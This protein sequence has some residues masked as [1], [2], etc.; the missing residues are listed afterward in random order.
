VRIGLLT[1]DT[2]LA[3]KVIHRL[4]LELGEQV[5][6]VLE[7]TVILPGKSD[8]ASTWFLLSRSS[9]R[10][11]T[12]RK[13]TELLVGRTIELSAK[14]THRR[15]NT[16][17]LA[18]LASQFSVPLVRTADINEPHVQ[19]ALAQWDPD[20][21]VSV[22]M[23]QR[24]GP[25]LIALPPRGVINVH[26]ALLPRNRG[27]FPYFWALAN[28]DQ[29]TGST[30]HWVDTGLDTGPILLQRELAIRPDHTAISL[31]VE[32]AD[33]GTELVIEAIR[34]IEKDRAPRKP[35]DPD[36]A[37]YYSWPSPDDFRRLHN[38]GRRYGSI[39]D[40]WRAL[41]W[42]RLTC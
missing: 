32:T 35:Q 41:S 23:N 39:A 6:G 34:L 21:L 40:M 24:I 2:P 5:V 20:L 7:G 36:Q 18:K 42:S 4:L 3:T 37:S 27:L 31:A 9:R 1:Y 17:R 38:R 29:T 15:T 19:V 13:A 14:V 11:M 30:V 8:W 10:P 12:I 28:G 25:G 26:G 16:A 33:L 22:S